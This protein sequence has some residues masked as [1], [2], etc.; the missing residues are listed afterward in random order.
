MEHVAHESAGA[1]AIVHHSRE[2]ATD[3]VLAEELERRYGGDYRV[4]RCEPGQRPEEVVGALVRAG[5]DVAVVLAAFGPDDP[6]AIEELSAVRSVAPTARRGVVVTWGDFGRAAEVFEATTLGRIEFFLIR[7]EHRRDEEFHRSFSEV[8][9]DWSNLRAG[10]FEA[11]RIVDRA[12]SPRAHELLDTFSRNHIPVG[13]HEPGSEVGDAVLG[14]AASHDP[15]LPVIELRFTPEAS[16][17]EDPTDL[18]ISDAFGLM[19]RPD[20]DEVFDVVVIGAGPGGL[21]AAVYAASE[22]LKTLVIERQAVGGQA[23]T[24]SLIRNYPGFPKGVSGQK[25]AFN[26]FHQAWVFGATFL[27]M[28][29]ARA[30]RVDGGNGDHVI[31]LTDGSSVRTRSV[32][33]ANGVDYRRIGVEALDAMQGRGVFYG[34]AVTEAPAMA[35]RDVAVVGGGNSAGQAAVH[36]ARSARHVT[37]L[38]RGEGLAATMSNYL[39]RE[40]DAAPNIEVMS[41]CEVV[42]GGG[43]DHLDHVVV[44]H[45]DTGEDRRLDVE[46]LFLLIG[47]EPRTEWL[48]DTVERDPWGFVCTGD[49]PT[50]GSAGAHDGRAPLE[51][52]VPGVFAV[53]DVRRGSVKRVASAV[54]EGAMV[55]QSVHRHLDQQLRPAR[56]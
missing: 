19:E 47:S 35:G 49:D 52:T 3:R 30:L 10:G 27:F 29:E 53:G 56:T 45:R 25:L 21:A 28:R 55:I 54:G 22:G 38:V 11:V 41:R 44:R 51:T 32:V 48:A 13:L 12:S 36:L 14:R 31:E 46:G 37:I 24:S 7:P 42:G 23:G 4:V 6:D 33:I 5:T 1:P 43:E 8:L 20:P 9:E 39:V 40:I 16:L 50:P 2:P 17:L 34:A 26:A 15:A 18:E